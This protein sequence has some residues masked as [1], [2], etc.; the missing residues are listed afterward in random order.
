MNVLLF[1]DVVGR[2][3]RTALTRALP[4]LKKKYNADLVITN[5]ENMAHGFGVTPETIA[6]VKESGVDICTTGNHAWKNIK[7]VQL[8]REEPKD[9]IV[10]ANVNGLPGLGMTRISVQGA[11]VLV[12]NLIGQAFMTME[13][14]I[15]S[16]FAE[17]DSILETERAD[18]II[19]DFH[20]EATGEKRTMSW[21]ADG[22]ISLLVGTHT[23]IQTSDETIQP[24]GTGYITDLGMTGAVDT[25]LGMDRN[26]AM[27]KVAHHIDTH[28]EPPSEYSKLQVQGLLATIDPKTSKTTHVERIDHRIEV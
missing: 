22:R 19:V 13:N 28:L 10:P 11:D 9:I 17:L 18:V 16:P 2:P 6:E 8:L 27:Q 7:G 5:V 1:G 24:Q 25:S 21:Y 15:T 23:H 26:M 3:G 20:A 12:I 14:E 4:E